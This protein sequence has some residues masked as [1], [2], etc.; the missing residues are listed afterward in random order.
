MEYVVCLVCLTIVSTGNH[1]TV[2]VG[3][4]R[5]VGRRWRNSVGGFRGG[6]IFV[7]EVFGGVGFSLLGFKVDGAIKFG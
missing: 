3:Q 1:H 4:N 7:F 5:G 2:G 6:A